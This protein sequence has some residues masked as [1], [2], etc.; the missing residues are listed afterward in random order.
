MVT[1]FYASI[2]GGTYCLVPPSDNLMAII[3]WPNS[4]DHI[5]AFTFGYL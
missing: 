5:K 1:E 2:I 3:I 4:L